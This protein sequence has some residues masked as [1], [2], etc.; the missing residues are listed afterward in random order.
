[1]AEKLLRVSDAAD[2]LGISTR[3]VYRLAYAKRL[4][5]RRLGLGTTKPAIRITESSVDA[6]ISGRA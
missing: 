5:Y 4:G 3:Q 1:M 6:L 2:R